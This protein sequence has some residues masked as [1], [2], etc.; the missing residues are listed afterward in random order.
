D[1]ALG[2]RKLAQIGFHQGHGVNTG[3]F[4]Q[5][6]ALLPDI[7]RSQDLVALDEFS[8]TVAKG[9][10]IEE[11]IELPDEGLPLFLQGVAAAVDPAPLR[12]RERKAAE[13]ARPDLGCREDAAGPQGSQISGDQASLPVHLLDEIGR[14]LI[15]GK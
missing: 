13:P 8:K 7:V 1:L 4:L 12:G 15:A 9:L 5:D 6:T 2:F 14:P 3:D 10:E 11:A